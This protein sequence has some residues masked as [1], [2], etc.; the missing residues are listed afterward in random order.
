MYEIVDRERS[1]GNRF[2]RYIVRFYTNCVGVKRLYLVSSFTSYIPGRFVMRRSGD[3]CDVWTR[4]WEGYY[5]YFFV[6][7]L[8]DVYEDDNP[9][10]IEMNFLDRR[11]KASIADVGIERLKRSLEEGGLHPDYIEHVET[12]PVF[13]S[14]YIDKIVIRLRALK[15]EV[16]DVDV[17]AIDYEGGRR[18]YNME[19]FFTDDYYDYFET[20]VNKDLARYIFTLDLGNKKVFYG[21]NGF[22]DTRYIEP[23]K[24]F[25]Y[26]RKTWW[27]GT[28]YYLIFPDSFYNADPNNDPPN[29]ISPEIIP[30]PRGF[31]GGDLKGVI[32]K[33]DHLKKLGIEA[34][35]MTPIHLS[36]S[37]HRYDVSD[38][39]SIDPYLGDENDLKRLIE[40]AHLEDI[41][42]IIDL[43]S[44][45]ASP[46]IKEMIEILREGKRSRFWRWFRFIINDL[47]ELDEETR[48]LFRE[49]ILKRCEEV[50][51]RLRE[52]K[53]FYETFLGTWRMINWNH[54]EEEVINFFRAYVRYW[55]SLGIDGLRIDVAHGI[56]DH[57][58]ENIFKEL[59]TFG[60][61]KILI[62]EIMNDITNYELGINSV[63]AMN[64]DLYNM[65]LR[66]FV[67]KEIDAYEYVKSLNKIYSKLPI[68][69][70]NSLY[71][72]LSSHD[73]PRIYT[74]I[75]KDIRLLKIMYT[76]LFII[77]GSPSIY[78]G[79]EIG[80]E[81][82]GDPDN[83]RA[84]IWD[85]KLWN[86]EI[87]EHI[88][89]L[90]KL[91]KKFE[92]LRI[93]F[94][95]LYPIDRDTLVIKRFLDE[96][97]IIGVFTRENIR[98]RYLVIKPSQIKI[99]YPEK[100][101]VIDLREGYRVLRHRSSRPRYVEVLL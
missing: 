37:Y 91:R 44:H 43:V 77:Y 51:E 45:H 74:V 65:S 1:G 39:F 13:L 22:E 88:K 15:N 23:R 14:R 49:F 56:P 90:I 6:D 18:I 52:K 64:Y 41:K 81:G 57:S 36:P 83:R 31:L 70:A 53:P 86:R 80:M 94:T 58:I 33:I 2:G 82:G 28:I 63:S 96:E 60:E 62:L 3:I 68:Y 32:E 50:P 79:D 75:N 97:S 92:T 78:Y 25:G 69:T 17:I 101:F 59:R 87:Y 55:L 71:N 61:D 40:K 42:I 76:L 95:R 47:D 27:I 73:T 67:N 84:M 10:K 38:Y 21:Y 99:R 12:D 16:R 9:N 93:G 100:R 72:L 5:P 66:F 7:S 98:R 20:Y 19:K 35:Y 24:I 48:E 54:D 34:I 4:L 29:K 30:R 26:P 89:K 11:I 8:F 46:C 85:E